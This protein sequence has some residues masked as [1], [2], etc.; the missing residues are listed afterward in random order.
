MKAMNALNYRVLKDRLFFGLI[1]FFSALTVVPLFAIIWELGKKGLR[2]IN[3]DFFT[4]VAPSTLDAMLARGSGEVIP[5]GIANG[6]MGTLLMVEVF[7]DLQMVLKM[8]WI[9]ICLVVIMGFL[10]LIY[11]EVN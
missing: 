10:I 8:I 4:Q 6:I 2:Q 3:F 5:G 11:L 9:R 7:Q 1:C